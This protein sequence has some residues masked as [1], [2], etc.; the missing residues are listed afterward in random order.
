[1][2]LIIGLGNP[3][4]EYLWTRHNFGQIALDFYAKLNRLEWKESTKFSVN[5]IKHKNT[6]FAKS[7][8]FYNESGLPVR[9]IVDYYDL[10]PAKDILVL[11]DDLNLPLGAIRYRSSGTAGGNNGLKSII[12]HLGTTEFPRLRLGTNNDKKN[13]I[14]D[15][16]FV[17][18]KFSAEEKRELPVI[19][20]DVSERILDFIQD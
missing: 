17:L 8:T 11:C 18:S 19:L 15:T 4:P 3:S 7:Q 5:L 6:I 14:S 13:R 12:T 20:R 10:N 1:M 9:R 2:K 16:D